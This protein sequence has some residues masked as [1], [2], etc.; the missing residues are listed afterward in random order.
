M[1]LCGL[2]MMAQLVSRTGMLTCETRAFE[3]EQRSDHHVRRQ[4]RPRDDVIEVTR[5]NRK[6]CTN[7][8]ECDAVLAMAG[9]PRS[10]RTAGVI[11]MSDRNG[12]DFRS[13]SGLAREQLGDQLWNPFLPMHVFADVGHA[14]DGSRHSLAQQA[15]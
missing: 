3:L 7:G 2:D 13:S 15:V 8:V 1:P 12:I 5:V 11:G 14:R 9:D 4:L 10:V 6:H